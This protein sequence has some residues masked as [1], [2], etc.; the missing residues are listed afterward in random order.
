MKKT[1]PTKPTTP[2]IHRTPIATYLQPKQQVHW[3]LL[4]LNHKPQ[5]PVEFTKK[6][7]GTLPIKRQV[8]HLRC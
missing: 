5:W 2:A 7:D 1:D 6:Y 3:I 4:P 8:S